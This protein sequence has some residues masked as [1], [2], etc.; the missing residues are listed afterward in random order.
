MARRCA[1]LLLMSLEAHIHALDNGV[2]QLPP[3]GFSSWNSFEC[4][5]NETV[6]RA[7]MDAFVDLGLIHVR[8]VTGTPLHKQQPS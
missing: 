5:V 7:T 8:E 2:G 3:L 1:I 6:M 4:Q